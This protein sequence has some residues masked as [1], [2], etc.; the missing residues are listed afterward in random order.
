METFSPQGVSDLDKLL[1]TLNG[2]ELISLP[3]AGCEDFRFAFDI[4]DLEVVQGIL[5]VVELG[6]VQILARG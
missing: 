1:L 6:L 2:S 3:E 5:E 4:D